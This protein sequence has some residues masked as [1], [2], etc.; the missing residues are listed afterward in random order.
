MRGKWNAVTAVAVVC[1]LAVLVSAECP[2][3]CS[4]N[5]NCMAK[6]MCE[7]FQN[8][9]GNDCADRTCLFGRAHVD[10][11]KGDINMDQ[12]RVT[13]SWILT[14]SQQH[15][16][17]TYEHFN[18]DAIANEAHFYMECSNKGI[19]DRSTG[20]CQCFDGYEGNGCQR[21][22]CPGK[23]SGHG[24]CE[25]L[26]ELGVKAGGT[27]IGPESPVGATKYDF[28]DANSTY[29]CRC[30]PWYHGPDCGKRTCKVG[31]DPMFKSA[32][33]P[34]Y[35]TFIVHA[36]A[37]TLEVA[38]AGLDGAWIRLRLFDYHG[39][40]YITR[41]IAVVAAGS[42]AAA[43]AMTAAI[44]EIPNMTFRTVKCLAQGTGDFLGFASVAVPSNGISVVCQYTD[45]PGKMRLPEIASA[46]G[47]S[48]AA[49][50]NTVTTT[51]QQGFDD[52]WFTVLS[53]DVASGI[54]G[55]F[56]I[57]S[58]VAA[59]TLTNAVQLVKIDDNIV[60]VKS[61]AASALTL[62]FG[63]V[64]GIS[65]TSSVFTALS[66]LLTIAV[67]TAAQAI[68]VD[69]AVGS[70]TFEFDSTL[71]QPFAVGDLVFF[72]NAFFTVQSVV[73]DLPVAGSWYVKM[74]KPFGGDS[75]T[76]A[77]ITAGATALVY[78]VTVST[79]KSLVYNYVSECSGRGIC[80][81]DTGICSCFKGYTDDNCGK[82]NILAL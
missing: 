35:E 50:L 21:T 51:T 17:G 49:V 71:A 62:E 12:S 25:S 1:L 32:G 69:L 53:T 26:R 6:D 81:Y 58:T 59:S 82:Q 68:F 57:V 10:T 27:L 18:P 55:T 3:G 22:A 76:G 52:E 39:E 79:D 15:P 8:Y 4:G 37:T 23:C 36:T 56:L 42:V 66:G 14:G 44:Q 65:S 40:S 34:T 41:R 28:W 73:K 63:L 9:Q 45:N 16:L 74:D 47:F 19:C 24:T 78:K 75:I 30:D 33:I 20:L 13:P 67:P 31:I 48:G 60:L 64:H 5:G 11:P 72:H 2:N 61:V 29:G 80:G 38:G 77:A 46:H 54:D 7:C 70:D 43:T